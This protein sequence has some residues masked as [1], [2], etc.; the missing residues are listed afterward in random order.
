MTL[1]FHPPSTL[2]GETLSLGPKHLVTS[3]E[4]P[5]DRAA[6]VATGV[7]DYH[8]DEKHLCARLVRDPSV[9]F[10]VLDRDTLMTSLRSGRS[11]VLEWNC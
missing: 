8:P 4:K 3:A 9:A 2:I 1:G 11:L 7:M 10:N 5:A 6:I